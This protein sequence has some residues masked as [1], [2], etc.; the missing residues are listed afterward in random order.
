[1]DFPFKCTWSCFVCVWNS[2]PYVWVASCS[3]GTACE[4]KLERCD[5]GPL[6]ACLIILV[7]PMWSIRLSVGLMLLGKSLIRIY[8]I[9]RI[10]TIEKEENGFIFLR[11]FLLLEEDIYRSKS[12]H[13]ICYMCKKYWKPQ[14]TITFILIIVLLPIG[15]LIGPHLF[16]VHPFFSFYLCQIFL[17]TLFC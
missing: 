17:Q 4:S 10:Y 12:I 15:C 1:M 3:T 7:H 8:R 5:W 16:I 6:I 14:L 2:L 11:E 9:Y 13:V